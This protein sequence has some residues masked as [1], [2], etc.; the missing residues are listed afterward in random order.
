MPASYHPCFNT[1]DFDVVLW[2][3]M[4]FTKFVSML[5]SRSLFFP[6]SDLFDDPFEGSLPRANI[7]ARKRLLSTL[8][9][10]PSWQTSAPFEDVRKRM[11]RAVY[12]NCWHANKFES[13][14]MWQLYA[15][16]REAVAIK[17]TVGR[18]Y[19]SLP[20]EAMVGKVQYVD[21]NTASVPEGNLFWPFLHKRLSF[22]H[23]QEVRAIVARFGDKS[24]S[25]DD[26]MAPQG[27]TCPVDL[28]GLIEAVYVAPTCPGWFAL[29]VKQV[30]EKYGFSTPV[31]QS[32]L[33]ASPMF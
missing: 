33:D 5:E 14:G 6:R 8:P 25:I 2:R 10:A 21:Y 12:V 23:E 29:L 7:E 32:T 28:S 13:A 16:T 18:L 4:D 15:Q 24:G 1:P 22:G 27:I 11:R 26:P 19:A 17:T 30:V 9:D 31:E 20:Q 3:Y